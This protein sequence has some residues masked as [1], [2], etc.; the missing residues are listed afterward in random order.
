MVQTMVSGR[1]S[2]N[3]S[4]DR[5][6]PRQ[7]LHGFGC[8]CT[9]A[10]AWQTALQRRWDPGLNAGTMGRPRPSDSGTPCD[11]LRLSHSSQYTPRISSNTPDLKLR[12]IISRK[13]SP[14]GGPQDI[15]SHLGFLHDGDIPISNPFPS[16][17]IHDIPMISVISPYFSWDPTDPHDFPSKS[18]A[19]SQHCPR[20]R[21]LKLIH[22]GDQSS[23]WAHAYG[24]WGRWTA[25][26]GDGQ[27][28]AGNAGNGWNW[29]AFPWHFH[30]KHVKYRDSC[31]ISVDFFHGVLG[32]FNGNGMLAGHW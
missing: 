21:R 29:M 19:F 2:L 32:G 22:L 6:Q 30:G 28:A 18:P 4:N 13:K 31:W 15:Q 1:F 20:L 17:T 7:V 8:G 26:A 24:R 5:A 12:A 27:K 23:S 11:V 25:G 3:Q 16:P 14:W 9:N 10:A